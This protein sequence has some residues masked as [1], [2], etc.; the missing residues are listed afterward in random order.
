M[1]MRNNVD[2]CACLSTCNDAC[3]PAGVGVHTHVQK[4]VRDRQLCE[5]N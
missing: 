2:V 4:R 1:G 3:V 5:A